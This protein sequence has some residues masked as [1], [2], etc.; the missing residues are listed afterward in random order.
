MSKIT[1]KTFLQKI[2]LYLAPFSPKKI[3]YTPKS[4]NEFFWG[5]Y[6]L[7]INDS[8]YAMQAKINKDLKGL[9]RWLLANKISLNAAKTE[10]IIFR[11]PLTK[12]PPIKIKINGIRIAQTNRVKYLG[13]YLD[14]YLDVPHL[15]Y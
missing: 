3:L 15:Y 12:I 13:V 2:V 4:K 11:K 5:G 6:H 7:N 9:Y 14:E 1:K 8:F 10:L